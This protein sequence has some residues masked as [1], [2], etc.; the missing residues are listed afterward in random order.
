M[1]DGVYATWVRLQ[2]HESTQAWIIGPCISKTSDPPKAGI[3]QNDD[4][5]GCAWSID[6]VLNDFLIRVCSR[7]EADLLSNSCARNLVDRWAGVAR[8]LESRDSRLKSVLPR[9]D[10]DRLR[11]KD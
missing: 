2:S 1:T 4:W 3:L 10:S 6:T 7:R 8:L 5:E 9:G 11:V